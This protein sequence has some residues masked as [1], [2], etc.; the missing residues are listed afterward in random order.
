MSTL[1]DAIREAMPDQTWSAAVRLAR[2]GHARIVERSDDEVRASVRIPGRPLPHEVF[3]WLDD[4]DWGC[5]CGSRADA[6]VHVAAAAIAAKQERQRS[7]EDQSRPS[8]GASTSPAAPRV[9]HALRRARRGLSIERYIEFP[10]TGDSPPRR[11]AIQGSL[12]RSAAWCSAGDLEVEAALLTRVGTR[13]P[14]ELW[15]RLMKGLSEASVVTLDGRPIRCSPEARA[16]VVRIRDEG[17]GFH[18]QLIRDPRIEEVFEGGVV[19]CGDQL[20]PIPRKLLEERERQ[21]LIRGLSFGPHEVGRLVSELIPRLEKRLQIDLQTKRLPSST[22]DPPRLNL[23][24]EP[25]EDDRLEVLP[26]IVYGDPPVARVDRERLVLLGDQRVPIRD[27]EREQRLRRQ[28]SKF[29]R[30]SPGRRVVLEAHEAIRFTQGALRRFQGKVDGQEHAQRFRWVERDIQPSCRIQD[31]GAG[32]YRVELD[33]DGAEPEALLRCWREGRPAVP[34][35]DGGFAPIPAAWLEQHGWTLAELMDAKDEQGAVPA[36]TAAALTAIAEPDALPPSL[37]RLRQLATDFQ[38]LPATPPPP[39]LRAELRPYQRRGVD[40]LAFLREAEL[41]GLL[42]DDMGLGKTLQALVAMASVPGPSLV[43]APTSVLRNWQNEAE[44]FLPSLRC[45]LYHGPNREIDPQAQLVITSYALLRRDIDTLSAVPWR[46]AVLDE[47]Q[48]IKNPDSQVSRAARRIQARHRLALTGTPVENRLD[49]L[50]SLFAFVLPGFLGRREAFAERVSD[51]IS[52]PDQHLALSWLRQRV[53]PFV[54]RRLKAEVAPEL[55]ART[56]MIIR[57]ELSEQ[58]RDIYEAVRLSALEEVRAAIGAKRTLGVLEAL[59]RLRQAACH[60]GLL[61]GRTD[62]ES[63]KLET[64]VERVESLAS[65]GH[66]ALVFS[67]WTSFLDLVQP[68]LE[69][70]GI[71][72]CRLDGG[73]RDRQ[74]VVDRFQAPDGPPVFLLSLKAGGTGLNLTAADYVFH[75]DPWWNPAVEDQ[76]VDRA[77]RIG[78]TRPVFSVRLVAAD[79]VEERIVA[80]Q[81]AKRELA[82][83]A[84]GDE[85]LLASKLSSD[86][87]LALFD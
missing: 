16:G 30:T 25:G 42:A 7:G 85:G 63:A 81:Q 49:E 12:A 80:L 13:I 64:L 38:G 48:A 26:T 68:A 29:L 77:H 3:L 60:P 43:V 58:E 69:A 5:D 9:I 21:V 82:R 36:H 66:R 57:C 41:G 14:A 37:A 55:P 72:S 70:A 31:D 18:V 65:Q 75:L 17:R 52:G 62:T 87:L 10:A 84:I 86:E 23:L 15:P 76:A 53:R 1:L 33:G 50:W 73:T 32:G 11:Q 19:R 20:H 34:L 28:C 74:A 59:L 79:T 61:P 67:Q 39:G 54:L 6:C 35:L 2:Q 4:E 46:Y 47:A 24:L 78:Q 8:A 27:L 83:A 22:P 40:W 44:R 45:C 51:A 71:D 56:E